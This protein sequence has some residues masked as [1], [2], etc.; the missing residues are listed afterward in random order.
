[1]TRAAALAAERVAGQ[2][3]ELLAEP[4]C[5]YGRARFR[6]TIGEP[7]RSAGELVLAG[8]L[9]LVAGV[10]LFPGI[11]WAWH[12]TGFARSWMRRPL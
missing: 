8:M 10:A 2:A 1:M 6:A 4:S 3:A 12:A 11:G 7:G 9:G 5:A